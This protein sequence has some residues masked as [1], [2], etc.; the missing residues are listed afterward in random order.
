MAIYSIYNTVAGMESDDSLLDDAEVLFEKAIPTLRDNPELTFNLGPRAELHQILESAKLTAESKGTRG[1]YKLG[2]VGK[3]VLAGRF[4]TKDVLRKWKYGDVQPDPPI[5]DQAE[6]WFTSELL[7]HF[8]RRPDTRL[9][10]HSL[11][12][13]EQTAHRILGQAGIIE[14]INGGAT[15]KLGTQGEL[16]L[17]GVLELRQVLRTWHRQ[18]LSNQG[19]GG[20]TNVFQGP[21]G[22]VATGEGSTANVTVTIGQVD[23]SLQRLVGLQDELGELSDSVWSILRRVRALE[24]KGTTD[25]A[26]I[27][28]DVLELEAESFAKRVKPQMHEHVNELLKCVPGLA[29]AL[30]KGAAG[31]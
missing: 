23:Q 25:L 9:T 18:L 20:V 27:K 8:K 15:F 14:F 2:R 5:F 4:S 11:Q 10:P 24:L 29:T 6:S 17:G 13:D 12:P 28:A 21:V 30:L 22:A 26:A 3:D 1:K 31:A 7:P 19:T 16:V